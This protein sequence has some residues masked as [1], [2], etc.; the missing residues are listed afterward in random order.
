MI[1]VDY[2]FKNINDEAYDNQLNGYRNYIKKKTGKKT[3]C[4]LYSI[5]EGI[6]RLVEEQ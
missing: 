2:K 6:Y 5:M 1:I 3:T 4:Y